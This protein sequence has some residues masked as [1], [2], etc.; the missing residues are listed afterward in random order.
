[1]KYRNLFHSV[2]LCAAVA[3]AG[4]SNDE[5][6]QTGKL[7]DKVMG[8]ASTVTFSTES[9]ATQATTM[10]RTSISHNINNGATPYWSAGDK[11]WVKDTDGNF[12][13]SG[14]GT[15]NA[16]KTHG[17][18]TLSGTFSNGCTVNYT[19]A[20]GTAGDKVTI[21]DKQTQTVPND[22]SHA[23]VSGDC[24]TATASGT[25]NSFKFKLDHKAS[26][27]CFLPRSSS[28][29]V[30][31]SKLFKIEVISED[32]IAGTYDFSTGS[33]SNA[34]LTGASK[35]ITLTTGSG[36]PVT[37][38]TT[39]INA[40]GAYMVIAPGTHS[41]T[42]RYWLRNETDNPDGTIEG[43]VTKYMDL[44]CE[45]GKIYDVTANLEPQVL[46]S[47][48]YMW[49]AKK[50][51]WDGFKNVQP[52]DAGITN[53]NYPKS[54][55]SDPN[56]WHYTPA[57][58]VNW[59][60]NTAVNCASINQIIWYTQKGDPHWDGTEL[61]ILLGRLRKGG[62]WL[63]KKDVIAAE[64]HTTAQAMYDA[65]NGTDYRNATYE[66]PDYSFSNNN[67]GKGRPEKSKIGNYFYLPAKGFYRN[68]QFQYVGAYGYYWS[69][70]SSKHNPDRSLSLNFSSTSISLGSNYQFYGFSEE[71]K[72]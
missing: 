31:R 71:L 48:Y 65:Y 19:G 33:L 38:T 20:N 22:F 8:T 25:G 61:W 15:F 54:Q 28:E 1:M 40:N 6:S 9:S 11:I 24:G 18:F 17:V 66:F 43:T 36:F 50:E 3:L 69:A 35:T 41:L 67:I 7:Q 37:N 2:M 4:C 46:S 27:L 29:Y 56:R 68:G 58:G 26:Y 30:H 60:A 16:D 34:P 21:A 55:S 23:G 32:A 44:A 45:A 51:Y 47:E 42:V 52:K 53:E 64:N 12:K 5:T 10:T 62:M 49:D 39:D 63:K 13:Q 72:W 59:A 14:V 57:A 70:T